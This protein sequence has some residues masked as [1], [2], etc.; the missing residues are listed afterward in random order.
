M[1]RV[2]MRAVRA[3]LPSSSAF[4][5]TVVA[6]ASQ[7]TSAGAT[8]RPVVAAASASTTPR[9]KSRGVVGTFTTSIPPPASSTSTTS[10]KVPPMSTPMRQ[11]TGSPPEARGPLR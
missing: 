8:P 2:V 11:L 7:A 5:T 6:W 9:Q 1:P 4:V 10:V 3:P